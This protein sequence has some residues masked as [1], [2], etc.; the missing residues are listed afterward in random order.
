[1]NAVGVVVEYNP[2]HNGH[3]Y[4]IEKARKETGA[5]VVIAAMS[6][7]FLQ[8]GEPALLSKWARTRMALHGGCDIVIELPYNF[9]TQ[10]A[11]S[12]ASGAVALLEACGCR[13]LSFG[14]ESGEIDDFLS[15]IHFLKES[16]DKYQHLIKQ[17][18]Q[19]GNSYP[20]AT[21]LAF[22]ALSPHHDQ[23]VDLS[24]PNNILGFQ[25]ITA[26]QNQGAQMAPTTVTRKNADYHD[27]SFNTS[28]IASATSLRKALFANDGHIENIQR[29]VPAA[30]YNG[31]MD[32]YNEFGLFHNWEHY[33]PFLQFRLIQTSPEELRNIYE[34]EEGIEYRLISA[35]QEAGSFS[36]FM[37]NVKTKRYT[38]TRIQRI[39]V[40]IL[41]NASKEM[42]LKNNMP[43]YL[44]LLGMTD[45]GRKYLHH[46]KNALQLPMI[47]RVS[48]KNEAELSLDIKASKVYGL[49]ATSLQSKKLLKQDFLQPPV[50]LKTANG[51][52]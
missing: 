29:Y 18:V 22:K 42:M 9:A 28:T 19:D 17:F 48:S 5:D 40:H 27:E 52:Q 38:W 20:K 8:R 25:Y 24:K 15:T 10:Q 6:G 49:A 1:M 37:E 46:K 4:H 12:F 21:S 47:S 43:Q 11:N 23:T 31:L 50:L 32:Y 30:T 16:N 45:N 41:T 34:V 2:F 51:L 33:W 35:A 26:I 39:C 36:E 44:R 14:S 13:Y 7:N 3:A